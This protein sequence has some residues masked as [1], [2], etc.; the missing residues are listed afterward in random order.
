MSSSI[1]LPDEATLT[2][3]ADLIYR[4][5]WVCRRKLPR[6]SLFTHE[7]LVQEGRLELLKAARRYR[8]TRGAKPITFFTVVLQNRYSHILRREWK[9][10][11]SIGSVSTDPKV[12]RAAIG[13]TAGERPPIDLAVSLQSL[14][15]R[16]VK[17]L[18]ARY[19]RLRGLD[20]ITLARL[21]LIPL[22]MIS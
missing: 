1:G 6:R 14:L 16:K 3:F 11:E 8:P 2:Q 12:F 5:S 15:D 7:D 17:M 20:L 19:G 9:R 4:E 10:L 13:S 18:P 21:L 22:G